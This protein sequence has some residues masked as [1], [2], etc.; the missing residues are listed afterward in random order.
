MTT[1]RSAFPSVW[2]STLRQ[3]VM[4]VLASFVL[5]CFSRWVVVVG[6]QPRAPKEGGT[7]YHFELCC[8]DSNSHDYFEK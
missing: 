8:T 3:N 7:N 6:G 5:S 4:A 2:S 1:C